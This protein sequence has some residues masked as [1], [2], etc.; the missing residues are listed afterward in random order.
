MKLFRWLRYR[1]DLYQ[2]RRFIRILLALRAAE[3]KK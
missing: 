2:T 3:R 1:W